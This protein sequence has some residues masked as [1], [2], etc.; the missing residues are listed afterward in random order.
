MAQRARRTQ[1]NRDSQQAGMTGGSSHNAGSLSQMLQARPLLWGLC[2]VPRQV[3]AVDPPR[4]LAPHS[5]WATQALH[6]TSRLHPP[7]AI[8]PH[9]TQAEQGLPVASHLHSLS[10]QTVTTKP[11]Q[12]LLQTATER[13]RGRQRQR[14]R[15][16]NQTV[17]RPA[18]AS[19]ICKELNPATY[20]FTNLRDT[21]SFFQ[22][23]LART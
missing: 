12:N 7:P 15:S 21:S 18:A 2:K 9:R 3:P 16:R 23:T 11:F 13:E 19:F 17:D 8:V 4:R 5:S 1:E 22:C 20:P 14:Q 6:I 10:A